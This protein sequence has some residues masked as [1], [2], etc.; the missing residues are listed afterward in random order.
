MAS[1]LG[2]SVA[3]PPAL[4]LIGHLP[5]FR[6]RRMPLLDRCAS[7][8]E[9]AVALRIGGPALLLK[10]PG[11][12]RH[13][14]VSGAA[15]YEKSPRTTGARSRRVIGD[16]VFA[17]VRTEHRT[18]R[19]RVQPAFRHDA[20]GRLAEPLAHRVGAEL[21]GWRV[22]QDI[23]PDG[24][25]QRIALAA[26]PLAVFGVSDEPVVTAI[27]SGIQIRRAAMNGA[28]H[29]LLPVPGW[30]PLA[31][32]PSRRRALADADRDVL[33]LVAERRKSPGDDL[34]SRLAARIDDD[35]VVRDEAVGLAVMAH[36]AVGLAVAASWRMLAQQ[37]EWWHSVRREG[38]A[39]AVVAE[40]LRLHPPTP[41]I[42]RVARRDDTLPSGVEVAGGSKVLLSPYVVQRDPDLWPEPER[43]DPSRFAAGDPGGARSYSYFPFG[44]GPRVCVGQAL[45]RLEA[46]TVLR[47]TAARFALAPG[48]GD[49][50]TVRP[51]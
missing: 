40:T 3:S 38:A 31:V 39:P 46:E 16:T 34:L 2:E 18:R 30:V 8:P 13:V 1:K 25:G 4:P 27:T 12:V 42:A 36:E 37:P 28:L 23:D 20:M 44:A 29:A 22:G 43:F 14:L 6:R 24:E 41:L 51:A 11:D 7:A 47:E 48:P 21:D 50:L 15:A 26:T 33:R 49:K 19:R 35:L 9:A 5:A 32:R 10:R 45:A 17:A